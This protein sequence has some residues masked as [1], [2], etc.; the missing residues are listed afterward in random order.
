MGEKLKF[1]DGEKSQLALFCNAKEE[2]LL[3][4]K[5]RT[6]ESLKKQ[7]E[8]A[9]C[10]DQRILY[11]RFTVKLR[12]S[13]LAHARLLGKNDLVKLLSQSLF[14][15]LHSVVTD[16]SAKAVRIILQNEETSRALS[17]PSRIQGNLASVSFAKKHTCEGLQGKEAEI[18]KDVQKCPEHTE[19]TKTQVG[20]Q[21][22]NSSGGKNALTIEKETDFSKSVLFLKHRR[23]HT[24]N[25][26]KHSSQSII[27]GRYQERFLKKPSKQQVQALS[28][29]PFPPEGSVDKQFPEPK[30]LSG[31]NKKSYKQRPK[32]R[33][34]FLGLN[35]MLL[36]RH[37]STHSR[38]IRKNDD[39]LNNKVKLF[40]Q[41]ITH[42]EHEQSCLLQDYYSDRLKEKLG[43]KY[44][45]V[46]QD[47]LLDSEEESKWNPVGPETN[48][49]SITIKKL[50]RNFM[51]KDNPF[52]ILTWEYY[53]E[54]VTKEN[55]M[56]RNW[57]N[58]NPYQLIKN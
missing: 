7:A 2:I 58:N 9:L 37:S 22:S 34:L 15:D 31:R 45:H 49:R 41:K 21:R 50:D 19:E 39:L 26:E 35:N 54:I 30:G 56:E 18:T 4:K 10:L 5:L 6:L 51:E 8:N 57:P 28:V 40:L 43:K 55:L 14:P 16:G 20:G 27:N 25:Y 46:N 29:K 53:N 42:L 17:A 11:K 44:Y 23:P 48:H 12:K 1:R 38:T 32:S 36:G 3:N 13:E 47:C 52:T 24:T 33:N